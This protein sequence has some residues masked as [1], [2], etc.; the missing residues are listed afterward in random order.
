MTPDFSL[1]ASGET[2]F[3]GA[4]LDAPADAAVNLPEL[5]TELRMDP[6]VPGL[7]MLSINADWVYFLRM[8]NTSTADAVVTVRIWLAALE[9]AADRRN[10]IEMDKFV[11]A[12]PAGAKKV[13]AAAARSRPWSGARAS[14]HR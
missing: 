10:W 1:D 14:P 5:V 4:K 2:N 11:A 13:V 7:P 9:L 12:I 8:C 6:V 3:G